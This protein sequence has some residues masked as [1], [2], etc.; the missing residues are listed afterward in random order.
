MPSLKAGGAQRVIINIISRLISLNIK[1]KLILIN[2]KGD[3]YELLPQEVSTE[4]LHK[5]RVRYSIFA[6]YKIIKNEQPDIV[7]SS[8]AHVNL[9]ILFLK[10]LLPKKIK[11]VVREVNTPS[12]IIKSRFMKL[13]YRILYNSSDKII[14]QSNKIESELINQFSVIE[15]K[16]SRINNPVNTK[17][18]RSQINSFN[19][20]DN[21]KSV[22]ILASRLVFQK[23]IDELIINLKHLDTEYL[24]V[25]LGEGPEMNKLI[26]LVKKNNLEK[27]ILFLGYLENPWQKIACADLFLLPS[28][29]EGTP[30]AA[31]EALACGTRVI[32]TPNSGGLID[33]KSALKKRDVVIAKMGKPFI[34]AIEDNIKSFK[35]KIEISKLPQEFNYDTTLDKYVI[36]FKELL[37]NN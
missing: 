16:I 19:R 8:L 36:L 21:K 5:S 29:W 20:L 23:G 18:I 33:L 31:L 25:I 3:L 1:V 28:R 4:V 11:Y 37:V 2:Y 6:I 17:K 22:L 10:R 9:I 24:L 7:F 30:N 15:N 32:A 27:K 13:I 34:K 14:A 12:I 26:K 35:S